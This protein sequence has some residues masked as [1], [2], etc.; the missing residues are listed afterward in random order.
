MDPLVGNPLNAQDYNGYSYCANN[1][2]TFTDPSGYTNESLFS[3]IDRALNSD[4]GGHWAEG[5]GGTL[6][7]SDAEAYQAG[8]DY[9]NA[10]NSWANTNYP[11]GATVVSSTSTKVSASFSFSRF[12]ITMGS[13]LSLWGKLK[14][15][16]FFESKTTETSWL[17]PINPVV[18][19]IDMSLFPRPT[20]LPLCIADRGL[21]YLVYDASPV[22]AGYRTQGNLI[23]YSANGTEIGR[24]SAPS[25]SNSPVYHTIPAGVYSASGYKNLTNTLYMRGAMSDGFRVHIYPDPVWDDVAGRNR[26]G[27]FIHPAA[28]GGTEGWIGLTCSESEIY[29]FEDRIVNYLSTNVSISLTVIFR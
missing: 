19:G 18:G 24:W 21:D 4:F 8:V 6:F 26:T 17:E 15:A 29:D 14:Y 7:T 11:G 13:W 25:G 2:L 10:N 20:P 1:P 28:S 3:F 22:G 12:R 27:L 9:N 5:G 23:W 16:F